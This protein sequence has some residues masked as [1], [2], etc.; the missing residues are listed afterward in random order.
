MR[1]RFA[2]QRPRATSPQ[3]RLPR[4][5]RVSPRLVLQ[6]SEIASDKEGSSTQVDVAEESESTVSGEDDFDFDMSPE[7]LADFVLLR[8]P[9]LSIILSAGSEEDPQTMV[10]TPRKQLRVCRIRWLAMV[11][12]SSMMTAARAVNIECC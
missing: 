4:A 9:Q 5:Q 6:T 8:S 10:M 11:Q 7:D 1:C 12:T 3:R 2:S